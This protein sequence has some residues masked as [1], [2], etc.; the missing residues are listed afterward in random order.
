MGRLSVP[1]RLLLISVLLPPCI[2][3][4]CGSDKAIARLKRQES[5]ENLVV[6]S[7][8]DIPD[9]EPDASLAFQRVA[10][11]EPRFRVGHEPGEEAQEFG[12]PGVAVI[13]SDELVLVT[14]KAKHR[15]VAIAEE[16]K[17]VTTIGRDG[18]GPGEFEDLSQFVIDEQ[19]AVS[20]LDLRLR[21]MVD[22]IVA[23]TQV[24]L[25]RTR[26]FTVSISG[27]EVLPQPMCSVG[28]E[29]V[30]LGYDPIA[31]KPL[32]RLSTNGTHLSSF[33]LP[34]MPGSNRLNNAVTEGKLLC[35]PDL[36]LVIVATSF[37]DIAAFK[38]SGELVWR[39]RLKD[40]Y[41]VSVREYRGSVV[42]DFVPEPDGTSMRPGSLQRL[43]PTVGLLQFRVVNASLK[44]GSI[45]QEQIG[46]DSRVFDLLTGT[47]L[48]RQTDLGV[49]LAIRGDWALFVEGELEPWVELRSVSLVQ[50]PIAH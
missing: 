45:V 29:F 20:V 3:S 35:L 10:V 43:S 36:G 15:I 16:G 26:T 31:E 21:R 6:R 2:L 11:G 4:G 27:I 8:A 32:H 17:A 42:F 34:F 37:G 50:S 47:E 22:L 28:S 25:G 46:I 44:T 40:F 49:V 30:A 12:V 39:R 33:G 48:G 38:L 18:K 41:P 7:L 19:G 14:D 1:W 9:S 5:L 24:S 23:G 13:L